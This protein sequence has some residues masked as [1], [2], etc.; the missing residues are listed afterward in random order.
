MYVYMENEHIV[1]LSEFKQQTLGE[2]IITYT[3]AETNWG[4]S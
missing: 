3:L 4:C 2:N 1:H